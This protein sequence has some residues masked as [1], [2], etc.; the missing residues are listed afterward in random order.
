MWGQVVQE[1][2][3]EPLYWP[4]LAPKREVNFSLGCCEGIAG[5]FQVDSSQ[6]KERR[7]VGR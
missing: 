7:R 1:V 5:D 4:A 3:E 2:E 6:R